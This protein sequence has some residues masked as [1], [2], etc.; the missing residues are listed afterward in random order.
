MIFLRRLLLVRTLDVLIWILS[1]NRTSTSNDTAPMAKQGV[2][3]A[4][5][6]L[7]ASLHSTTV[8]GS[9]RRIV[10]GHWCSLRL[11]ACSYRLA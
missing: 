4:S 8:V 2:N 1:S 6:R 3:Q 10:A 7:L 9:G 11:Y 5:P